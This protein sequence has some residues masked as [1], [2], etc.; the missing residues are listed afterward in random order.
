MNI[1]TGVSYQLREKLRNMI[2]AKKF[3][4]L[5]YTLKITV[6]NH[7]IDM[8]LLPMTGKR[9]YGREKK[10]QYLVPY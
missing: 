2:D 9:K 4:R 3:D 7:R 10:S 1:S 8:S 6:K 5:R